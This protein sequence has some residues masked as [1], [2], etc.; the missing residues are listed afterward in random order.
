[1][2]RGTSSSTRRRSSSR[3]RCAQRWHSGRSDWAGAP[4]GVATAV[5]AV[6]EELGLAPHADKHPVRPAGADPAARG[7]GRR[8]GGRA[9]AADSR[10]ADRRARSCVR[11]R[12]WP[13]P[14]MARRRA[15]TAVLAVTHDFGF[16]AEVLDRAV[17]LGGARVTPRHRA[18]RSARSVPRL[19]GAAAARARPPARD[20]GCAGVHRR[21]GAALDF[22]PRDRD[23]LGMTAPS[24][25]V[26]AL[27]EPDRPAADR[28]RG[29]GPAEG[30]VPRPVR[31]RRARGRHA[32][33][34]TS[35]GC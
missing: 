9:G 20:H 11:A 29:P 34:W 10:R 28:P 8:P 2:W 22:S 31:H 3:R 7:A 12:A 27:A 18:G 25:T 15:G 19:S 32:L 6:L 16:A 4:V 5:A 17:V 24:S 14:C 33:R 21:A 26:T 13:T 23:A 1:M 35:T 30:G